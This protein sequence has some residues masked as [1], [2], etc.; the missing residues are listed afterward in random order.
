MKFHFGDIPRPIDFEPDDSWTLLREPSTMTKQLISFPIGIVM[1]IVLFQIWKA[2]NPAEVLV[3]P[4]RFQFI[5][6]L[7]DTYFLHEACHLIA[8]PN[9]GFSSKSHVV[10]S[11]SKLMS[12]TYYDAGLRRNSFILIQLFP[13]IVISIVAPIICMIFQ[14]F[15]T[16]FVAISVINALSAC[17]DLY[18]S[19]LILNQVPN[20]AIARTY[21]W[22]TYWKLSGS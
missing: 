4:S 11:L 19:L 15:S 10:I 14:F 17:V 9:M 2:L 3:L 20:K 18:Y 7:I 8:H 21:K 12:Y 22:R 16:W 5:R 1:A 13:L 6:M